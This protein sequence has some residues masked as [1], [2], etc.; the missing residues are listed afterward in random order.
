MNTKRTTLMIALLLAVV[1]GWLTL[2]YVRS[3]QQTANAGQRRTVYVATS[4]IPARATI[5]ASMIQPADRPAS[6]T[7]P[8]AVTDASTAVGQI[9]LITIPPGGALTQ[10]NIGRSSDAGLT[11]RLAPGKRAVSIQIDKV[12]GVSG[13]M[14]PGDRVDVIAVPSARG[15]GDEPPP[16]ATILRGL[17]VLAV[18]NSIEYTSATP[19][20][21]E[22]TS[23][24]VTLE[25]SPAQADLLAMADQN[26]TLRLALRSPRESLNSE[27]TE[28]L[29]FPSIAPAN[30]AAAPQPVIASAPAPRDTSSKRPTGIMIID[31]D[32]I[33]YGAAAATQTLTAVA[34][35]P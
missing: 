14:Q 18:G 9:A 23:T 33:S 13:L 29:R 22:E 19:S 21:Q 35:E 24:T 4:E 20:P 6:A 17:R 10:S 11:V 28:A 34:A 27:P 26:T 31:G 32:R 8:D 3:V 2:N 30:S 7:D 5:T 12:K 1:T 25:V 15:A 16:A